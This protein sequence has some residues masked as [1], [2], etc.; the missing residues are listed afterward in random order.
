MKTPSTDQFTTGFSY[1][2]YLVT[3]ERSVPELRCKLIE[4][5]HQ[6]SGAKIIH[7]QNDDQEN[8]FCLSFQTLPSSSNGIAHVLEHLVLCGSKEF[9]V[10]DPF[11]SMTRRSMNTFMNALTG[12]DF[13]CYPAASQ[14][15]Q[16]F[17]NLLSVYLDAVF[18]PLLSPLSFLQEGH[19]LEFTSLE[20]PL[21]PLICNGVVYNEMKGAIA[22]PI[23]R[24]MK[25]MN[26]LLFP[27]LPYGFDSGGDPKE[28]PSLSLQE[29]MKFHATY[30]HPSRCIYFFYGNLPLA[31][32]LDVLEEKVL[33]F[34]SPVAPLPPIPRQV[35]FT[36]PKSVT[37]Q[38]PVE[39]TEDLE[40]KA[41]IAFGW[42]TSPLQN[43]LDCLALCV[44]DIVLMDTDAS[45]LKYRLL[46]SGCC[47][48]AMSIADFEIAEVPYILVAT[49][50]DEVDADTLTKCIFSSLEEISEKGL[51][52]EQVDHALHQLE[53][54]KSE[55]GGNH[56][57]FGLSLY[58]RSALL[59]H[60]G[61]DPM[62]GLEIHGL[63]EELRQ[64][65]AFDPLFFSK[66][67]QKYFLQN[68]HFVRLVMTPSTTM[69]SLENQQEIQRLEEKRSHLNNSQIKKIIEDSL[70]LKKLQE[71]D[72]DLSCLPSVHIQD[73][74]KNTR[75][76]SL[77]RS[78]FNKADVFSHETF[79]NDIGYLD[80][81]TPLPQTTRE[82]LWLVRL[83]FWL[84]PQL[85]CGNRSYQE[86]LEYL[87]AHTGGVFASLSLHPQASDP[88]KISPSWHLRGKALGRNLEQLC[89]I[90]AD[91]LVSPRYDERKRIRE[92][93][94]KLHT[95]LNNSIAQRAMDYALTRGASTLSYSL[96]INEAW[97]GF[98]FL[99][100]LRDLVGHY[101]EKEDAL[102]A[103]FEEIRKACCLNEGIHIV[104]SCD[105]SL[106]T[107]LQE[108]EFYGLCDLPTKA[109]HPWKD[110]TFMPPTRRDEGFLISS[111]VGF[112]TTVVRASS[113]VDEAAA[114]LTILSQ[115]LNDTFLHRKLRE[116]GGAYGGGA[117][118]NLGT[119]TFSFYSY[120]DPHLFSSFMAFEDSLRHIHQGLFTEEEL[121][122]AKL[123]VLQ[124]IDSPIA[125][126]TRGEVAYGWWRGGKSDSM[127]QDFRDRLLYATAQ[128]VQAVIPRFFPDGWD[129]NAFVAFA[130]KDLFE[131]EKSLFEKAGRSLHISTI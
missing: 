88:S 23:R 17:Y 80:V 82:D 26:S 79:T 53:F 65:V 31:K 127:R 76:L 72:Q 33:R 99:Q 91:F 7:L 51:P 108:R 21:S 15:E 73:V 32:H 44:L 9:P 12:T 49:G 90:L 98:T 124:D 1:G 96:A 4:V 50:S 48:Q 28:I 78:S 104:T 45:F 60:H 64:A 100:R 14:I 56:S 128:Q 8:L 113:Y 121:E 34:A 109:F 59:A 115:L 18:S 83:F 122:Q 63:F 54:S 106:L 2:Q 25:E 118:A 16:D 70:L 94:E 112:T 117:A 29:L 86:T 114:P 95:D 97:F 11:F 20:D 13:T 125:P 107:I 81:V 68:R 39:D 10:R 61:I 103:K 5:T 58:S 30:Y 46:Q 87:Q 47:R 111:R 6:P 36:H 105:S 41:Y 102:L 55:I 101:E 110:P 69:Q 57:P 22:N 84:L 93:I 3:Q 42:L 62:Q 116:Q 75:H 89:L 131:Q 35:R 24:I 77:T 120:K 129:K 126:G 92:L 37:T 130:G 43:Q 27:D 123:G 66:L 52:K 85:G 67:L 74:P 119:S 19:R 40:K 38:Y 71:E